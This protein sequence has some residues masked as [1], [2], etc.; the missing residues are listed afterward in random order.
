VKAIVAQRYDPRLTRKIDRL[1]DILVFRNTQNSIAIKT[2]DGR[3]IDA[4]IPSIRTL[5]NTE[6]E[7]AVARNPN[8]IAYIR[9][10]VYSL[11]RFC[12]TAKIV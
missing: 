7:D 4:M 3:S 1:A 11:Y 10:V 9:H 6:K 8:K 2:S 12:S 5:I